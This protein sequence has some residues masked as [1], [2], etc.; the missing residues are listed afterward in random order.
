M[1]MGQTPHQAASREIS[2]RRTIRRASLVRWGLSLSFE[3][4]FVKTALGRTSYLIG[5]GQIA[6]SVQETANAEVIRALLHAHTFQ[7]QVSLLFLLFSAPE[8][9]LGQSNACAVHPRQW[10]GSQA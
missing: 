1:L 9:P 5:L 3:H 10:I 7:Q 8:V 4:D 6:R 2:Q